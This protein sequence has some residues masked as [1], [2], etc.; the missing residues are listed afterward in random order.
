[1]S[2]LGELRASY[3]IK[4]NINDDYARLQPRSVL[5]TSKPALLMNSNLAKQALESI[6][7]IEND[8]NRRNQHH[9]NVKSTT[10]FNAICKENS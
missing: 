5:N 1:M 2:P 10:S 7:S 9:Q 6:S 3:E 8:E 4:P